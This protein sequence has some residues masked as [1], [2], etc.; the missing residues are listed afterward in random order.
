MQILWFQITYETLGVVQLTFLRLLSQDAYQNFTYTCINSAAWYSL[1]S[2]NYESAI[3]LLGE[4]DQE[5][6]TD[7]LQPTILVDGCKVNIFY[8]NCYYYFSQSKNYNANL[9]SWLICLRAVLYCYLKSI[10]IQVWWLIEV[11]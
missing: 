9:L 5:F 8:F 2:Y 3:K 4:N 11:Y 10:M 7:G 6:S 1:K